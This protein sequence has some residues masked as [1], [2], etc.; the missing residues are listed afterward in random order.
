M[1][2]QLQ[3]LPYLALEEVIKC[4]DAFEIF[5]LIETSSKTKRLLQRIT[6][7]VAIGLDLTMREWDAF[8]TIVQNKQRSMIHFRSTWGFE[9][10]ESGTRLVSV[11]AYS[12]RRLKCVVE[13]FINCFSIENIWFFVRARLPFDPY[14]MVKTF[15]ENNLKLKTVIWRTGTHLAK[16][17]MAEVYRA[18]TVNSLIDVRFEYRGSPPVSG[19][20]MYPMID[21]EKVVLHDVNLESYELNVF[22]RH[23]QSN[24]G[25]LI[26][27]TI[28]SVQHLQPGDVMSGIGAQMI[29]QNRTYLCS[30]TGGRRFEVTF[31]RKSFLLKIIE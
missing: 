9:F 1:A 3:T 8:F 13:A 10:F 4:M 19:V 21:C 26:R 6:K 2:F 23:W 11:E 14:W 7:K 17:C 18:A 31:N 5:C 27:L 22:L 30:T 25:Y 16:E 12:F 29:E 15:E 24:G 28:S 20:D